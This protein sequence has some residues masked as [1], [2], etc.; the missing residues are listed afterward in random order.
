[1][2]RRQFDVWFSP[3][4][5]ETTISKPL[6]QRRPFLY[7]VRSTITQPLRTIQLDVMAVVFWVRPEIRSR[8]FL[9]LGGIL[10]VALPL[11]FAGSLSSSRKANLAALLELRRALV[12]SRRPPFTVTALRVARSGFHPKARFVP[13]LTALGTRF[14]PEII[15]EMSTASNMLSSVLGWRR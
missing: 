1:M 7:R 13:F 9:A 10:P 4:A 6:L 2:I 15:L 8:L 5:C 3:T 11:H 14:H 12:F